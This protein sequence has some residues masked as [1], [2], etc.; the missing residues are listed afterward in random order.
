MVTKLRC[1]VAPFIGKFDVTEESFTS[2]FYNGTVFRFP[3]RTFP[4]KLCDT[5]YSSERMYRLLE[6]FKDDA[7]MVL[8]FLMHLENIE[9]YEQSEH[10]STPRLTFQV[11]IS[12]KCLDHVRQKR[13]EFNSQ[14]NSNIIPD[15]PVAIS[16]PLEIETIEIQGSN[17]IVQRNSFLVTNYFCGSQVSSVFRKLYCDSDLR[18]PPWVGTALPIR[19]DQLQQDDGVTSHDDGHVFCFLPLPAEGNT[20]TGLP[21]HVN[22]FFALEQN[23]KY[24]KM[25]GLFHTREDLM[26]KRLLWNQCMM[27]EALPRAYISLILNAIRLQTSEEGHVSLSVADVYRAF[28][29]FH[30]VNRNWDIILPF[31]YSELFQHKVIHAASNGGH[32]VEPR[33]AIFNTLDKD[34]EASPVIIEILTI[35]G[36]NIAD[37][38]SHV[39]K[40][41]QNCCHMVNGKVTPKLVAQTYS[42]VQQNSCLSRED[43][44]KLL[45]YFLKNTKYDLLDGLELLP[46]ANDQFT[47]FTLNARRAEKIIYIA[48]DD[49]PME[50]LPGLDDQFLSPDVDNDIKTLLIR[51]LNRGKLE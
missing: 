8:I 47:C 36:I 42:R 11:R 5:V 4:S 19:H 2:G 38:P 33:S 23:R 41:V 18:F 40:A 20:A 9:F 48:S 44:A 51:A 31:M 25:P 12:S 39:L 43:R 1:Q 46:L 26:D 28:P 3:L 34:E 22:G 32:W 17:Q 35:G 7:H 14:I 49:I 24:I 15:R 45:K 16:Y 21:V 37:V 29:D 50:L 27:K 10:S 6:S 30:K 13:T